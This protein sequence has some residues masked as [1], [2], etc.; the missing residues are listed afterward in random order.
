PQGPGR[1]GRCQAQKKARPVKGC[2]FFILFDLFIVHTQVY[3]ILVVLV[4]RCLASYF[5]QRYSV[6]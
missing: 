3:R 5:E 6:I 4:K 2:A 1:V